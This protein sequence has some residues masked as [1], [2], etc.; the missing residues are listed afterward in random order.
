MLAT[1]TD[2][3]SF[4]STKSRSC[5]LISDSTV[6]YFKQT[7]NIFLFF[8]LDASVDTEKFFGL[9][10]LV[11]VRSVIM[12]SIDFGTKTSV[13][14]FSAFVLAHAIFFTTAESG[15][16]TEFSLIPQSVELNES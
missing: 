16:K 13:T 9:T 1:S 6:K 14:K 4:Y 5:F 11:L 7:L 8:M 3:S 10:A 12:S 2:V 15:N